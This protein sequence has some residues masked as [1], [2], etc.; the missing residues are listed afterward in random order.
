MKQY[1]QLDNNLV[2]YELTIYFFIF[3]IYCTNYV[4]LF[5]FLF[6]VVV[7]IY[8]YCVVH[9]ALTVPVN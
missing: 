7:I 6:T 4:M 8:C 9:I 1:G 3:V 5:L 2:L